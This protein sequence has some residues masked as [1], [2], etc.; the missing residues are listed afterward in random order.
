MKKMICLLILCAMLFTG[1]MAEG[2]L[3]VSGSGTVYMTADRVSA[4]MGVT[5]TGED[6]GKTQKKVNEIL[7]AICA[8]LAEAGLEESSISTNSIY[9]YPQYDYS[10][11]VQK[12]V[13]YNISSS[14]NVLTSDID[15]IGRYIDAAFAAGANT[16]DSIS[17]SATDTAA[18]K[19]QALE[20]AVAN[21]M[22]KAGVIAATSGRELGELK[23]I[24]EGTENYY[25]Y[26]NNAGDA[27]VYADKVEAA[28]GTSV[29]AAQISV[30][31]EVQLS[32]ELR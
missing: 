30:S 9:I 10:S 17:F 29:H 6:V 26:E 11:N 7:N 18:A 3:N 4:T 12:L 19:K 24:S 14:I 20:I 1:A 23:S 28:A 2:L 15:N 31:A 22:E 21:A 25:V 27:R 32:Y 13:G 5:M 16:F 8:A